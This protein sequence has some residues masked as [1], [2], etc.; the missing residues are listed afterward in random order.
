MP[1]EYKYRPFHNLTTIKDNQTVFIDFTTDK[2]NF[3]LT[4]PVNIEIQSSYDGTVNLILN[5]DRNTPRLI[6][7]GFAITE[8]GQAFFPEKT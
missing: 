3:R 2:L 5:D 1:L 4:N 6:N 8:D 7:S